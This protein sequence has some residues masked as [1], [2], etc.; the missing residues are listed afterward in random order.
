V[1][2]A[3]ELVQVSTYLGMFAGFNPCSRGCRSGTGHRSSRGCAGGGVSILVLVDVALEPGRTILSLWT[4]R[5]SILVLVDVA[6]ELS[7]G[8]RIESPL[9]VSILV[10]VDVALELRS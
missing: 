2:V 10:L 7:I 4:V 8:L 9:V 6:L 5:V 3:L 1:D